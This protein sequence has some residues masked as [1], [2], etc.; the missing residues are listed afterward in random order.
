[1]QEFA[2]MASE[3]FDLADKYRNP[4]TILA[5]GMLGQMMEPEEKSNRGLKKRI[6]GRCMN[7]FD[8]FISSNCLLSSL[9]A[10]CQSL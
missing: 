7:H 4:V 5:D 8:R 10:F 1:V 2:D 3:A 9:S 6:R